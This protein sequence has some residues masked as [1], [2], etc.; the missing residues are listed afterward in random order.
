MDFGRLEAGQRLEDQDLALPPDHP[1]APA[2]F[3]ALAKARRPRPETST[4]PDSVCVFLGAPIWNHAGFVGKLYPP[5]ARPA[6]Y[7]RN[8]ARQFN[9]IELNVTYYGADPA[10]L[11]KWAAQT[12]PGFRFCPKFPREISHERRL[13]GVEQETERFYETCRALGDRLGPLWILLPPGFGPPEL[14][15]LQH[16]LRDLPPDLELAVEAREPAWYSDSS[17]GRRL[18]DLLEGVGAAAILTDTA[19]RRDVLHMRPT[20]PFAFLRFAGN[21]LHPLDEPRVDAWIR[22]LGRWFEAG[23]KRVYWFL[24]Q[25]EPLED[26]NAELGVYVR[27]RMQELLG[28]ELS[29]PQLYDPAPREQSLFADDE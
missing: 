7:L 20:A 24:H 3:A 9:S 1:D 17:A 13:R 23:L 5:G 11:A 12:P 18:F 2:F 21:D 29:G 28:I 27:R 8:Y 25:P 22:R 4:L 19:G 15:R 14:D 16:F 6:D 10:R 26:R